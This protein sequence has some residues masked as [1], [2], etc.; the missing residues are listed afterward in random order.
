MESKNHKDPYETTSISF[1]VSGRFFFRGSFVDEANLIVRM[2]SS[3][4]PNRGE[5]ACPMQLG[6]ETFDQKPFYSDDFS[7]ENYASQVVSR[8]SE[9]STVFHP[10]VF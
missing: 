3:F 4:D 8:I 5:F 10:A 1:K 9:P 6:G 7:V 2:Q